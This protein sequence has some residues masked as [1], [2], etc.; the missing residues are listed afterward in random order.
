ME[1]EWDKEKAV[2]NFKK[3]GVSFEEAELAFEDENAI[4]IFDELN[5]DEEIRFQIIALSPIR[6]LFVAFTARE[7]KIRIISARKASAKQVKI[8]NEYNR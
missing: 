8:Y 5:S 4:E 3:H 7:E 6:L 2:A 1:F